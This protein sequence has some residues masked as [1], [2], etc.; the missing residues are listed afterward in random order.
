MVK[1][2]PIHFVASHNLL[3]G[4]RPQGE[5]FGAQKPH[6]YLWKEQALSSSPSKGTPSWP[7]P[8]PLASGMV[9]ALLSQP[10]VMCLGHTSTCLAAGSKSGLEGMPVREPA[11]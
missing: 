1:Y 2:T 7:P 11:A 4:T 9:S 8:W 3:K 5:E 10:P 6:S